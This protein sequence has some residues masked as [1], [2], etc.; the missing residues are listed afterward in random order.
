MA[1]APGRV[2][3]LVETRHLDDAADRL[4]GAAGRGF[5]V[6]ELTAQSCEEVLQWLVTRQ[7]ALARTPL[8]LVGPSEMDAYAPLLAE[9]GA[10][11]FAGS[12]R[13]LRPLVAAALAH[14]RRQPAEPASP[15]EELWQTLPWDEG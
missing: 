1:L 3:A 13:R 11:G 9:L 8:A 5:V 15:L 4:R 12:P 7:H 10:L 2:P 6:V 14:A